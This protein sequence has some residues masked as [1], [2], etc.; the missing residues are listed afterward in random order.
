V[1]VTVTVIETMDNGEVEKKILQVN[2]E[3]FLRTQSN[4]AMHAKQTSSDKVKR[5]QFILTSDSQ[6]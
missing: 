3:F 6:F 1:T 4:G 2:C 5:S